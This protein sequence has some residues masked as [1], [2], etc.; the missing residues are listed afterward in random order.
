MGDLGILQF[1][2]METSHLNRTRTSLGCVG[3]RQRQLDTQPDIKRPPVR[4][5]VGPS[6][7]ASPFFVPTRE[8]RPWSEEATSGHLRGRNALHQLLEAFEKVT[9]VMRA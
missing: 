3:R 2:V 8:R 1:S 7:S 5:G 4:G 9:A 6:G